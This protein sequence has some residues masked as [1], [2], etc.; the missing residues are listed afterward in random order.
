MMIQ[1]A[2]EA[3]A[4]PAAH[5]HALSRRDECLR[6]SCLTPTTTLNNGQD[7]HLTDPCHRQ[8]GQPAAAHLHCPPAAEVVGL[9]LW[10]REH[11][12]PCGAPWR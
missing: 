11:Q 6:C 8:S 10:R 1:P 7:L 12:P 9:L 2:Q 4:E 3:V 5:R